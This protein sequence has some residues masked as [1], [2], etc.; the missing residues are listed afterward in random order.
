VTGTQ[1]AQPATLN[2]W[3]DYQ[4][5][6]TSCTWVNQGSQPALPNLSCYETASWSDASCSWE[7]TR[8]Q[9]PVFTGLPDI[10]VNCSNTIPSINLDELLSFFGPPATAIEFVSEISDGA[11]CPETITRTFKI[12]HPCGFVIVTQ[13]IIHYPLANSPM[14]ADVT[15]TVNCKSQAIIENV[16]YPEVLDGCGNP[17]LPS[18]PV[19]TDEP[20]PLSCSGRRT[21]TFNYVNCEGRTYIWKYTFI[22]QD[23]VPPTAIAPQ[24]VKVS[25]RSEIPL[26]DISSITNVQDNCGS[27]QVNWVSDVSDG[28]TCPEKITRTYT[29]T[30][31]CGNTLVL[32]QQ[33]IIS[34]NI[35]PTA[36]DLPTINVSSL[37]NVP[38][39]NPLEVIDENDN[40]GVASVVWTNDS[41]EIAGCK[42]ITRTYTITDYCGNSTTVQQIINVCS[43][44]QVFHVPNTFTPDGNEYNNTFYPVFS[45]GFVPKDFEMLIFDRWGELI[46]QSNNPQ[47]G[48]DGTYGTEGKKCQDGTYTW[49]IQ[50]NFKENAAK[51]QETGHVNLLK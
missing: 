10:T 11:S 32:T 21:F 15:H 20:S 31:N 6:P 9:P 44:D 38:T 17:I 14:P 19:V 30:D 25:C 48:W 46:F 50:F 2:C 29:V 23:N 34:D 37:S 16:E 4:F 35:P 33:I 45:P 51:T 42:I 22:V 13:N 39:P 41:E 27:A 7:V 49:K 47:V 36:S 5:N 18:P 43:T 3:D 24:N 8:S 26:A 1:P 28:A 12:L 40:C